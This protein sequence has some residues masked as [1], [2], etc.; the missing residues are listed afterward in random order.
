M[1][2]L[3]RELAAL[4]CEAPDSPAVQEATHKLYLFLNAN[5][6]Q[7]YSFDAFEGLGKMYAADERFTKNIDRFG[8][9]LSEFLAKAMSAYAKEKR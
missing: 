7:H 4:R 9:G 2:G 1:N 5:F 8:E 6:G 3:F